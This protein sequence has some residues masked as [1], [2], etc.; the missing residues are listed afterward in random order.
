[1]RFLHRYIAF[2]ASK[3]S[4]GNISWLEGGMDASWNG[5]AT[6]SNCHMGT[7]PPPAVINKYHPSIFIPTQKISQKKSN[8]S[9]FMQRHRELQLEPPSCCWYVQFQE[10]YFPTSWW[11][12]GCSQVLGFGGCQSL[13]GRQQSL[14]AVDTLQ[15]DAVPVAIL[16]PNS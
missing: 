2:F 11:I 5:K 13:V 7:W 16:N 14:R 1:M 15:E 12:S 3:N 9:Q 8:W 4:M 10:T 6:L